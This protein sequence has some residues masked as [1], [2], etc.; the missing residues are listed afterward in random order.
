M[1]RVS[2]GRSPIALAAG[3]GLCLIAGMTGLGASPPGTATAR[4]CQAG[5]AALGTSRVVEIDASGGARYGGQQ[6]PGHDFLADG[7]VVLTF[8]DGPLRHTTSPIL[9]AL[10][11]HCARATFFMVG[12]MALGDP[13]LV[14]DIARRGH[15]IGSHTW[16]HA[17]QLRRVN[18]ERAKHE[19]ELGHSAVQRALGAPIAPFFRFP[20]LSD[21]RGALAYLASRNLGAF[22][23]DVDAIDYRAKGPDGAELVYSTVM[24]QLAHQR[25][26]IL[27]FH[28]IQ[29]ATVV[30]LPRILDALKARGFRIV[31]MV[32]RSSSPTLVEYDTMVDNEAKRRQ[33]LSRT[34]PLGPRTVTWNL[35]QPAPGV[36]GK[37]QPSRDGGQPAE[38]ETTT[39]G[40]IVTPLPA[41]TAPV[42]RS[43]PE[44]DWRRRILGN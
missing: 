29:P 20:F 14:K 27:L 2:T 23:I 24:S 37:A 4:G 39:P 41:A 38:P 6:Y 34:Q 43:Q 8:D 5:P 35:P 12:S 31:H 42:R 19:I 16:S 7:E 22:S 21:G 1:S 25:K 9:A 36:A 11:R 28:D 10:E 26:G 40:P 44:D 18:I 33:L 17:Y 30:A 13:A 32:A 3:L 15:T